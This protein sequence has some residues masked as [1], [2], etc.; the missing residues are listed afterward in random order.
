[1][2]LAVNRSYI[3]KGHRF[4]YQPYNTEEASLKNESWIKSYSFNSRGFITSLDLIVRLESRASPFSSETCF[5]AYFAFSSFVN[6]QV[7][8]GTFT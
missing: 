4:C 5:E 2:K 3:K 8:D 1:M 7:R 6:S